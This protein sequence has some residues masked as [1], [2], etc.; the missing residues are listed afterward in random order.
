MVIRTDVTGYT[1]IALSHLMPIVK[2]VIMN[3]DY[4]YRNAK[5][6]HGLDVIGY[7]IFTGCFCLMQ[8]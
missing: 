3:R 8:S 2:L 1:F 5:F 4:V 6:H 7:V